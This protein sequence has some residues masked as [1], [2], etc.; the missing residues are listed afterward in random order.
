MGAVEEMAK[1]RA[2]LGGT[3][4]CAIEVPREETYNYGVFE[5]DEVE[6]IERRDVKSVRGM[7][8]KPDPEN[9][10][11]NFVATG[12]YLLDRAIFDALRRIKPGKGGELQLTDAIDLLI[13]EGHPVHILVHQGGRHDLGNP[14]GYIKACVDFGLRDPKYGPALRTAIEEILVA[15]D[16]ENAVN[17]G[18][19]ENAVGAVKDQA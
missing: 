11:S 1:V 13:A 15:F 19:A 2:E 18:D 12:R 17:A 7:V 5:I 6:G 16:A 14:G 4:L 9:A 3:V 10:P 8:E